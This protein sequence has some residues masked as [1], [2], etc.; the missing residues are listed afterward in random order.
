MLESIGGAVAALKTAGE[1]AGS[2][3]GLRDLAQVQGKV[4]ELQ[5]VILAAQQS[6]LAAQ[7]EQ[8]TLLEQKRELE[9]EIARLRAWDAEKQRYGLREVAPGAVTH[10]V[11]PEAQGSEPV[12]AICSNC[13]EQGQKSFLSRTTV[14]R[15]GY[16]VWQCSACGFDVHIDATTLGR[17]SDNPNIVPFA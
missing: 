5:S 3:L 7:G 16:W 8:F 1:I 2:F 6:A 12:H 13:F 10:V 14:K 9:A 11:K 17:E 15:S 4:I